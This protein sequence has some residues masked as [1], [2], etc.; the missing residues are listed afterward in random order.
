M[1]EELVGPADE[2]KS[3]KLLKK[4]LKNAGWTDE[5]TQEEAKLIFGKEKPIQKHKGKIWTPSWRSISRPGA[6]NILEEIP[7]L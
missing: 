3:T 1:M 7:K 4:A 6:K 2:F 5:R